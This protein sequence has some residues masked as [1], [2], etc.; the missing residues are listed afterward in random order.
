MSKQGEKEMNKTNIL[1]M[2]YL[3]EKHQSEFSMAEET[4]D[5]KGEAFSYKYYEKLP[6]SMRNRYIQE[7]ME[8]TI[9]I[10]TDKDY[11]DLDD[12]IVSYVMVLIIDIFT[13]IEVPADDKEKIIYGGYLS[14]FGLLTKI[15]GNFNQEEI[16]NLMEEVSK[17]INMQTENIR[18]T[19]KEKSEKMDEIENLSA[20]RLVDKDMSEEVSEKGE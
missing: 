4:V 8:F 20:L 1:S 2:D 15:I 6:E 3:K 16:T 10:A 11:A 19:M 12:S 5:L 18:E 7:F 9:K 14:D 13:D 17:I